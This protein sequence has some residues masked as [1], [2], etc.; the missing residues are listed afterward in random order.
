MRMEHFQ[1]QMPHHLTKEV[2]GLFF[3]VS[4]HKHNLGSVLDMMA[5]LMDFDHLRA[6]GS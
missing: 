1:E 3:L 6:E 2:M 5:V 4:A